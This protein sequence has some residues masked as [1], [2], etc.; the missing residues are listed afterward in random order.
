MGV[1]NNLA[2]SV[3][4]LEL[5]VSARENHKKP[6]Q[7]ERCFSVLRLSDDSKILVGLLRRS[8]KSNAAVKAKS[9][10]EG[11]MIVGV[12]IENAFERCEYQ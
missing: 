9:T 3:L 11:Q 12:H 2:L 6:R 8:E 5:A 4:T 10:S 1:R 7:T